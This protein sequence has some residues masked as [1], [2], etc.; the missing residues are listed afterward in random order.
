MT[1]TKLL[2][3]IITSDFKWDKNIN[4]IINRLYARM[5]LLRKLAG[6]GAPISDLKTVYHT[7]MR[8]QCEQSSNILHSSLTYQNQ[9]DLEMVQ[10]VVFKIKNIFPMKMH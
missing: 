8:S 2:R 1:E 4:A 9:I 5:E 3:T 10:M 7:F 6:F